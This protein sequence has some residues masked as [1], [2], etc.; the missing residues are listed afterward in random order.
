MAAVAQPKPRMTVEE[1]FAWGGG[2]HAGKLELVDG[3]VRA[4]APAS[5][6]HAL[7]QGNIVAA[8]HAHLRASGGRCRVAPEA[9]VRPALGHGINAR[10]PDI[11]V[12]C[13]PPSTS[14]TFDE[15]ILIIEVMSPSN[16]DDTWESIRALAPLP[17]LREIVVVQS[18]R[19]GIEVYRKGVDGGWPDG[20]EGTLDAA[21][22]FRLES[23]GLDLTVADVYAGTHL[24]PAQGR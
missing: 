14:R 19:I 22:T 11:A 21:G 5:A 3:V 20:P 18:E 10:V 4:M 6:T 9:P 23:I 13:A 24:E 2:G 8:I 17:T 1:F 12:T 16:D 15:P 7:M